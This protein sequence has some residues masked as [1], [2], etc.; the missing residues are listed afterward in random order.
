[1]AVI[2]KL[3]QAEMSETHLRSGGACHDEQL[4][5]GLNVVPGTDPPAAPAL[6]FPV[7]RDAALLN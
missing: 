6:D 7:H 2:A 3:H 5:G 4:S 1:V